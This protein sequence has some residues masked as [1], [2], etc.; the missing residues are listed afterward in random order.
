MTALMN[1][2][3]HD[4]FTA[5]A[6]GDEALA[7]AVSEGNAFITGQARMQVTFA[8]VLQ[9]RLAE[10]ART[11]S[12]SLRITEWLGELPTSAFTRSMLAFVALVRGDLAVVAEHAAAV[13][14]MAKASGNP[15]IVGVAAATDGMCCYAHGDLDQA[16]SALAEGIPILSIALGGIGAPP[17]AWF[18][19]DADLQAGDLRAAR[20]HTA[21]LAA[22]AE[23]VNTDHARSRAAIAQC[24]LDL[25][26]GEVQA[27]AAAAHRALELA[28][29]NEDAITTIDALE[30][31][32]RIAAQRRAPELAT[33]LLAAAEAE[34]GRVGYVRFKVH[35]AA[36]DVLVHDLESAVGPADFAR[37]WSEG[38]RLPVADAVA[39]ARS[40][41]GS[42]RRPA[43]GWDALTRL[44][45]GSLVWSARG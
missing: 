1:T 19:A 20:E 45:C 4:L 22:L 40:R 24:G 23:H 21:Q 37:I 3:Y 43:T 27:A 42:R 35:A 12:E 5:R 28:R 29:I 16:R 11:G 6:R 36:H 31:L 15:V 26:D 39:L 17:S 2:E 32:A 18:L 10:A 30:L 9:G 34:R 14:A 38:E 13:A 8:S 25:H 7:I 44:S 41:R 33:R